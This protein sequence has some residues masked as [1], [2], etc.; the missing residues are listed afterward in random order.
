MIDYC[1]CPAPTIPH[2]NKDL[3]ID[4]HRARLNAVIESGDKVWTA[5]AEEILDY[6]VCRRHLQIDTVSAAAGEESYRLQLRDLPAA[7]ASRQ[8]T[9][10]IKTPPNLRRNPVVIL[11]GQ[12]QPGLLVKLDTLRVTVDLSQPV[13]LS[14]GGSSQ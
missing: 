6:I 3:Y 2:E 11:D 12:P 9:V 14:V 13:T 7:V 5:T 8:V 4:E 10:D 1:H